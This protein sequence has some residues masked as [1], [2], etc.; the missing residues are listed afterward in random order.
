MATPAAAAMPLSLL[1]GLVLFIVG[2][3]RMRGGWQKGIPWIVVAFL[4]QAWWVAIVAWVFLN[5]NEY[6]LKMEKLQ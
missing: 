3:F 6:G 5:P 1:L 2:L 4:L